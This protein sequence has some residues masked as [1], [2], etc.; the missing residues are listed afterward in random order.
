MVM[1]AGSDGTRDDNPASI[2]IWLLDLKIGRTIR[3]LRLPNTMFGG[4]LGGISTVL[5]GSI[6]LTEKAVVFTGPRFG[7]YLLEW[8]N[9]TRSQSL[10]LL[11]TPLPKTDALP[12]VKALS[13]SSCGR[14]V[15]AMVKEGVWLFDVCPKTVAGSLLRYKLRV[16]ASFEAKEDLQ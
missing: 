1:L 15:V 14:F 9:I 6:A 8:R 5:K 10:W 13:T 12:K 11:P 16:C 2:Y 7:I 4:F 3:M